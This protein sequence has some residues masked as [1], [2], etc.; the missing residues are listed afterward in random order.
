MDSIA[1]F[2]VSL[3]SLMV[4][5]AMDKEWPLWLVMLVFVGLGLSGLLLGRRRPLVAIFIVALAIIGGAGQV[6]EL[7]DV[8][9]GP[10]IRHEAGLGYVILSYFSIGLGVILPLIGA[11]RGRVACKRN[12]AAPQS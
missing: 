6:M 4:F 5:E 9:V 11:W 10:A 7:N 2:D 3:I 12:A 8:Y 1:G